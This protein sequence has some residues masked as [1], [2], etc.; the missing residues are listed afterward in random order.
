[1]TAET[2]PSIDTMDLTDAIERVLAVCREHSN[3]AEE[4]RRLP[5][6][7]IETMRQEK[8][9]SLW[10]PREYG[11]L[12][13][14]LP[15]F[16][17]AVERLA[18]EDAAVGWTFAILAAGPLL[19]AS[20][21]AP[22]GEQVFAGGANTS[23]PGSVVPNG[24]AI[25]VE[26]GYRLS[27]RWPLASGVQFG[28]WV[29]TTAVVIEGDAPRMLGPM[30]DLHTMFVRPEDCQ[31]I[32]TW[33]SLGMRGTGSID[34]VVED[35]FVP[36]ERAS[37]L[38]GSAPQVSGALYKAGPLLLFSMAIA[39]VLPGIARS[40]IDAFVELAK[41]KTPTLSQTGLATRPT[42]HAEVAK[43]EAQLQ[44][45]RTFF[46]AVADEVM[47]AVEGAGAVPED[48]EARRRLACAHLADACR[49]VV[50]SMFTLAGSTPI[51]TGHRLERCL[52]DIHTAGQHLVVSPVWWEKT[53][54]YYFGLGLG[55]P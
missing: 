45:A 34:F 16:L 1:M 3:E 19:S 5:E 14:P 42:I 22:G 55:M 53:G 51:Y 37:S 52:R 6:A 46:Y 47:T 49:S 23:A 4:Q 24:R 17:R 2:K 54:Q 48:L 43:A 15:D 11:G 26:G 35:V 7:V 21:P 40:A 38:F 39:S 29:G 44:S 25:P 27:G 20:L 13:A 8:L 18:T 9:F 50:D 41:A 31:F 30:P 28:D 32:D 36:A 10:V 12:E 33:H